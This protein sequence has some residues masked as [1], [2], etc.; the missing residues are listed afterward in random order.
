MKQR[1]RYPARNV[2]PADRVAEGR[3]ALRQR[4]AQFLG[5]QCVAYSTSRPERGAVEA[6]GIALRALVAIGAAT[7]VDDLRVHRANVLDVELVLLTL[8]GHVVRQEHV[9]GLGDLVEDLLASRRRHV[10]ADAALTAIGMLDQRMPVRVELEATHVDEAALGVAAH[11]M[12]HLDD[13]CA[14][15]GEDRPRR[16]HERELCN[17]EDA[18]TLHHLDQLS[19]F[20]RC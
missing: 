12:F 3:N 8:C 1:S 20:P 2:H 13:V 10:N 9:G 16:R 7:R 14:P 5:C 6:S 18:N 4:A 17:F 19:P 15:V 11:R